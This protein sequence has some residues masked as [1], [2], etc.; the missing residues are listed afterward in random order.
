MQ[1]KYFKKC[2]RA[3]LLALKTQEIVML[4]SHVKCDFKMVLI[5]LCMKVAK[6][7]GKTAK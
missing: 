5:L 7:K 4:I 6:L 1:K 3:T 2:E